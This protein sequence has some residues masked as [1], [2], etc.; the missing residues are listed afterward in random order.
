MKDLQNKYYFLAFF[1]FG[2]L[3]AFADGPD[4]PPPAPPPPPPPPP[5]GLAVDENIFV[6][7]SIAILFG[8][9]IIYKNNIKLKSPI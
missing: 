9:Y 1:L 8:I 4:P 5:P 7:L 6:L 3:S 2:V